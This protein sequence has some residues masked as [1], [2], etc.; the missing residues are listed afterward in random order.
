MG[1]DWQLMLGIVGWFYKALLFMKSQ[2][3][4]LLVGKSRLD[5]SLGPLGLEDSGCAQMGAPSKGIRESKMLHHLL[6][7]SLKRYQI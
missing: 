1:L 4:I 5:W 3:F 2:Y 7:E 6:N